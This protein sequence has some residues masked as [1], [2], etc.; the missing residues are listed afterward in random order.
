M[1]NLM[2]GSEN[3][4]EEKCVQNTI[5]CSAGNTW[6]RRGIK[7]SLPSGHYN[8]AHIHMCNTAKFC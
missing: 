4:T 7:Y 8:M 1:A 2:E 3:N 5:Q 6:G